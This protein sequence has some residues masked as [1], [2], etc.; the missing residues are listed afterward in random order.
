M[1]IRQQVAAIEEEMI[2]FRRQLHH[3]PETAGQETATSS[4][5]AQQLTQL[6]LEVT[7]CEAGTGVLAL[8]KGARPGATLALRA[9]MDAL[10]LQEDTGLDF[11]SVNAGV[12]HACGHDIHAT[13][14][15]GCARVLS[16]A[17]AELPGTVQFVFQP[18]EEN[19]S[20]ARQ[21]LAAGAVSQPAA[22]AIFGLHC[23]PDLA[24]GT[25][26]LKKGSFMAASDNIKITITGRAGHAAHPH[27]SIDP[28]MIAGHVIVALQSIISRE[29]APLDSAVITIGTINGGTAH[30]II[31]PSVELAG[32]V[33]TINPELRAQMPGMIER[34]VAHVAEGMRGTAVME[35][36]K[37]T[38]PV[39]NDAALV[40]IVERAAG[41]TLGAE[42]VA[43][44]ETAS[45]GGEDFAFY[46]EKVPGAMF[47]L[48]TG[49][50][51]PASRLAL[52][53]PKLIFDE[54][55]IAA[56]IET[57]SAAAMLYLQEHQ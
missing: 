42:K 5:I 26:G 32:T 37:G 38:P 11:A 48:G 47:R 9:D 4:L 34:V 54:R 3:H 16:A 22:D 46:L 28:I 29:V 10:P 33:R 12:T 1:E 23:W 18:A 52:H 55:A 27:K 2:A 50:D 51:D 49:N 30:N 56:G 36:I 8:L 40:G 39:I 31:A 7:R 6:G 25:V 20:G 17:K 24:A 14:L 44:L 43:W 21:M 19:L 57:M 13:V 41:A 53:N 15:L 35:Y 45:M